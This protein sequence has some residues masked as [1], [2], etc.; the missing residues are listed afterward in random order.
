MIKSLAIVL[1]C[2]VLSSCSTNPEAHMAFEEVRYIREFPHTYSLTAQD[3]ESVDF[4]IIGTQDFIVHDSLLI[5]LLHNLWNDQTEQYE[6][7]QKSACRPDTQ[8]NPAVDLRPDV[9]LIDIIE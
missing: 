2:L 8:L 9:A 5:L 4:G 6:Q 3:A 7:D 1:I